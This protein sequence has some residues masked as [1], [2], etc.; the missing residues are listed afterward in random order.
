M[1]K[2]ACEYLP[3]GLGDV[4]LH[5]KDINRVIHAQRVLAHLTRHLRDGRLPSR[6][7]VGGVGVVLAVVRGALDGHQL[8]RENGVFVRDQNLVHLQLQLRKQVE[9]VEG[10]RLKAGLLLGEFGG[11]DALG[12]FGAFGSLAL[13]G[14]GHV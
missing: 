8:A 7:V 9:E 11:L 14:T 5:N 13:R 10:D 2:D 6:V 3:A 4:R 12:S 1:K